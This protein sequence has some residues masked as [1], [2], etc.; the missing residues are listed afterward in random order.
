MAA[1]VES[2]NEVGFH[3]TTGS[4]IARRAGVSWGAIQHHFRDKNGIL[5]AVLEGSYR[6]FAE[7]I[8]ELPSE[9]DSL[10][11]R[12]ERFVDRAWKHFSSPEYH[13]TYEILLNL[14]SDLDEDWRA[15]MLDDWERIWAGYF[16]TRKTSRRRV[17]E[18]MQYTF[19][20]LSGL[21]GN[22]MLQARG[23]SI[24]ASGLEFLKDTLRR[25]LVDEV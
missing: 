16:P 7:N 2:I 10:E 13:S 8:G 22:R 3:R 4:E 1:V 23:E 25:G 17:A 19:A 5:V 18:L 6:R 24:R 20:V 21:A 15:G 9:E 11:D 12:V 14:P